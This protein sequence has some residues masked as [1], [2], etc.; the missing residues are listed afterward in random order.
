LWEPVLAAQNISKAYELRNRAGERERFQIALTY[1]MTVKGDLEKA[2]RTAE[3]WAQTYPRDAIPPGLLSWTDQELGKLEKSIEDSKIAI[4]LGPDFPPGYNNLAWTYVQL[5][6]LPEAENT[7]RRASERKLDFPEF[8]VMRYYIAFLKGDR[9]GMEREATA[10]RGT[11]GVEDWITYEEATVLAWSG[12]LQEARRKAQ[13]AV[14]LAHQ[15]AL[16]ERAAAYEAGMAVREASFGNAREARQHATAALEISKGR[17]V[18]YGA[19]LAVALAGDTARSQAM[20]KDLEKATE[21]TWVQFNYLPTLR[22]LWALSRGE[23]SEAIAELQ[24]AVPYER[25][26]AGSGQGFYGVFFPLYAR[27][28]AYLKA[29]RAS[30]AAAQFQ[31]IL[32]N[33]G[34]VFTDPVGVMAQIQLARALV[35]SGD[36]VKGRAAYQ[37][38]LTLWKDADRQAPIPILKEAEAEYAR[39]R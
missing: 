39:V 29:G 21:D 23:S 11:P 4:D 18:V 33:R 17:D 19:A 28:L 9:A 7:L 24:K 30:D 10:G 3:E 37:A 25:G 15:P 2:Q 26:V 35:M 38:F 1:E 22:A 8:A 20:A 36:T 32:D 6:R 5:G 16:R 27:G 34:I 12:R 31:T 13:L 14:Q